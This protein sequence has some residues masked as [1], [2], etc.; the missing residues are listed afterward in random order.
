[1][2]LVY[3]SVSVG[4]GTTRKQIFANLRLYFCYET[5]E[6]ALPYETVLRR[7]SDN[8]LINFQWNIM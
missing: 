6:L 3:C 4:V 1:M 5:A 8:C 2:V 7:N